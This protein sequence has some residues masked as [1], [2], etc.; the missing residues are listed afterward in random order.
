[1]EREIKIDTMLGLTLVSIEG[2][3]KGC[4]TVVF[5]TKCGRQFKMMHVQDCCETVSVED[6]VGDPADLIGHPLLMAEESSNQSETR[7][8]SETWT[9][10]KFAT[11]RGYVTLRWL[12]QSN[13]Y[14]SEAV[15]FF[16]IKGDA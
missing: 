9:F 11:S 6:V 3:G 1:M 2:M 8:G 10:Y 15:S 4:E 13:G 16:E 12:G 14:Y 7:A 5:K